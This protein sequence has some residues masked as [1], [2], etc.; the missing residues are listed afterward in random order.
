MR[1]TAVSML[2]LV[3]LALVA[4]GPTVPESGPGVGFGDYDQFFTAGR[5]RRQ[6]VAQ[7]GFAGGLAEVGV[8][9]KLCQ[10]G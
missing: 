10:Q 7:D 3:P 1:Y 5:F 2:F 9:V 4:C 8:A 6:Q